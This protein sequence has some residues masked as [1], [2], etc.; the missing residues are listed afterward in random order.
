MK[1]GG[2]LPQEGAWSYKDFKGYGFTG[3]NTA[4]IGG[5]HTPEF[6]TDSLGYF[7][8]PEFPYGQYVVIESTTP[9][10]YMTINPFI[11]TVTEDSRK[12]QP[13]RI[14]DDKE[15]A[16]Y[17]R[18]VKKDSETGNTILNKSAAY[19]IYDLDKGEYIRMKTTYPSVV[20]YG[21]AD[22][23]FTTDE[24]GMLITPEKLTYG[25]YRLDEVSAPKGYV[26]AGHEQIPVS[27]YNPKGMTEATPGKPVY[28][29]FGENIPVYVPDAETDVLE[30]VHYNGQQKGR[31]SLEKHGD[32]PVSV[33]KDNNGNMVFRYEDETLE[34]V[35]FHIIADGNI[36]SQDGSGKLL[37]NDGDV[38]EVLNTDENGHTWSGDLYI[39]NYIL[40]EV[41]APEGYLFVPDEYFSITPIHQTKQYTFLT[42]DLTDARQL[43]NIEMTK[44][45]SGTGIL[46]PGTVFTLYVAED[47]HFGVPKEESENPIIGFFDAV[48]SAL[49]GGQTN[50]VYKDEVVAVKTTGKDGKA[51][52]P[53]LPPGRYY[54]VESKAPDGYLLN[55]KF[56][57]EFT[58]GYDGNRTS[59]VVVYSGTCENVKQTV[60]YYSSG[61][62]YTPAPKGSVPKTGD[63]FHPLLLILILIGSAAAGAIL[64][65]RIAHK[66]RM[67]KK[68]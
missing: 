61:T 26:L 5:I 47:I 64:A 34:G 12:P 22:N 37:F 3:E 66:H 45:E 27:G 50:V 24:T 4:M 13:W 8:S 52:F 29:E 44:K 20:W 1:D 30:I 54:V 6:F 53:D 2:L 19:R 56:R 14:F 49:S 48:K 65:E 21:T 35:V 7:L 42:W 59:S 17:I 16:F 23:P 36:V 58:L 55:E 10:G 25:N 46:L 62:P 39:G 28:I 41:D 60:P 67:P 33:G 63:D 43:L 9:D 18:I 40:C 15:M 38:V 68:Q 31:I 57:A 51:V 32:K 11:V